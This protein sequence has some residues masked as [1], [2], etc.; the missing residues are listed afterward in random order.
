MLLAGINSATLPTGA[1]FSMYPHFYYGHHL[2]DKLPRHPHTVDTNRADFE[3][4]S[5][6][7]RGAAR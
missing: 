3:S 7:S 5:R 4:P 6:L 1:I 2:P